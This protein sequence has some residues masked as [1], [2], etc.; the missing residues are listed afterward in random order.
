[1][2]L[3]AGAAVIPGT[4]GLRKLRFAGGNSD[5]GK[6]GSYR[7]YYVYLTEHGIVLLMAILA[8]ND[9]ADLT[10]A[11]RN[12]L[13]QVIARIHNLLDRGEVR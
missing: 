8:K 10:K 5:Q 2:S 6:R 4:N 13:A 11:D 9:R 7:I 3:P 1:M 12:A